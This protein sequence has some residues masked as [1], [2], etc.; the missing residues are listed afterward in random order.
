MQNAKYQ[1]VNDNECT[2]FKLKPKQGVTELD[3]ATST[4]SLPMV[5]LVLVG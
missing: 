5:K 3:L 1:P 4:S 2:N